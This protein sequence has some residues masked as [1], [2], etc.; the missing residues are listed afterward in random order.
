METYPLFVDESDK[1]NAVPLQE[2]DDET[3]FNETRISRVRKTWTKFLPGPIP[4]KKF[5]I[6]KV[7]VCPEHHN[8]KREDM[9]PGCSDAEYFTTNF[10]V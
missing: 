7:D 10:M 2:Y 6:A 9:F 4:A 8:V 5:K 1:D 3:P